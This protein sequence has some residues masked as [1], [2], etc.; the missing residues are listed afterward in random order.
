VTLRIRKKENTPMRNITLPALLLVLAAGP[1]SAHAFLKQASPAVGST[2]PAAPTEV[3]ITFTEGVEPAFST[4]T[5]ADSSG[6]R[7]DSGTVH[8]GPGGDTL[9]ATSLKPLQPGTYKVTWHVTATDT[10]KTQGSF[11]FTVKP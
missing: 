5:V 10:H 6:A 8:L 7:V 4:I 9:L 3:A 2:V 1:A 11:T